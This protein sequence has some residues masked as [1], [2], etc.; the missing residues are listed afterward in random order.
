MFWS[1]KYGARRTEV[2]KNRPDL[3]GGLYSEL[4]ARGVIGSVGVA[5]LFWVAAAAIVMH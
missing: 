3:G 2:R 4:R 5:V 1:R